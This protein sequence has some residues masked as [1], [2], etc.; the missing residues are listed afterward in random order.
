MEFTKVY[1]I[2]NDNEKKKINWV[3]I[4]TYIMIHRVTND[5]LKL[6]SMFNVEDVL[7]T[8][9]SFVFVVVSVR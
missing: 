8:V 4:M 2:L 6:F 1:L 5:F 3:S 9:E 7:N